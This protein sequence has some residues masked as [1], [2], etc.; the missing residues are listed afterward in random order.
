MTYAQLIKQ[1]DVYRAKLVTIG[2]TVRREEY[3][4][5]PQNELGIE[6]YHRLWIEP[7]GGVAWPLVVY[8]L[9]VP[10]AFPRGDRIKAEVSVTGYFFKNWSYAYRDGLGIAPVVLTEKIDWQRK[11]QFSARSAKDGRSWTS[12]L[13]VACAFALV[14]TYLAI[15]STRRPEAFRESTHANDSANPPP[16]EQ[17]VIEHLKTLADGEPGA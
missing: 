11:A 10:E 2:G 12:S 7:R 13:I 17:A 4:T 16:D 6:A 5:A 1:P 8:C 9:E 15:R 14:V 3:Q